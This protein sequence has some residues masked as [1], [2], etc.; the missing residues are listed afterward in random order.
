MVEAL[1]KTKNPIPN[2]E[3]LTPIRIKLD[4]SAYTLLSQV[5]E[6]YISEKDKLGYL[7]GDSPPPSQIDPTF[8]KW[9]TENAIVKSWSI[10]SMDP[11]LI[12]NFIR[13][14]IAKAV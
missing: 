8:W 10:N 5:M 14:S 3:N 7:N 6:I 9:R 1:Y 13:F 4:C 12:G 2:T 11:T